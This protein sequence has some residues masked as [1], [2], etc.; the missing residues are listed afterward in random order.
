MDELLSGKND[1]LSST[2]GTATTD[3]ILSG[4][5]DR[6][7]GS[8]DQASATRSSPSVEQVG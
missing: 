4:S 6:N 2:T 3:S 5:P 1:E 7:R 8:I